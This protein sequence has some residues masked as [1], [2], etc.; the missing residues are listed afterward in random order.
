[1][2]QLAGDQAIVWINLV[3][4]PLGQQ[5]LVA[6]ALDLLGLGTIESLVRLATGIMGTSPG[7]QFSRRHRGEE[8]GHHPR[9]DWVGG[10]TLADR[11]ALEA[12]QVVAKIAVFALILHNHLAAAVPAPDK[13][14]KQHG[15]IAGS[16]AGQSG[17][18]YKVLSQD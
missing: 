11:V 13:A 16:A 1:M 6:Q 2:F 7:L 10:K 17:E 12:T 8:R 15:P 14:L 4:L 9:V 18:A 5:R 3:E